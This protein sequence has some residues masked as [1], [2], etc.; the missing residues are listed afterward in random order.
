[1]T[2]LTSSGRLNL[3]VFKFTQATHF[4]VNSG[5]NC[6]LETDG[7]S[8]NLRKSEEKI[9]A[10]EEGLEPSTTRLTAACST[11]ELLWNSEERARYKSTLEA[12]TDFQ[13]FSMPA[14]LCA[15]RVEILIGEAARC[16][17][18]HVFLAGTM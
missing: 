13:N 2:I 18:R 11:I 8:Q 10:P 17:T 1:M 9:M 6:R 12:S 7:K 3:S 5:V 14:T 15:F 4:G 16:L